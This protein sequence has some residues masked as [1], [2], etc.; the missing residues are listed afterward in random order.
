MVTKQNLSALFDLSGKTAMVTGSSRGIGL[1]A[2][3]ALAEAGADTILADLASLDDATKRIQSLGKRALP[4]KVD[5]SSQESI[6][7][8]VAEGVHQFGKVDIIV[9]A[10]GTNLR[11]PAT[12][13]NE[14]EWGIVVNVNLRGTFFCCQEAGKQMIAQQTGGKIINIASLLS[15]F[16]VPIPGIVPYAC[17]KGGVGGLTRSLAMEWAKYKINVNAIGP[18]YVSTD[19]TRSIHDDPARSAMI[20]SRIPLG[21]WSVPEDLK[22]A[23]VFLASHASDYMTGQIMFVDGGWTTT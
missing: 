20:E 17:S 6:R 11:K 5:V 21:R 22:G 19:L 12:D 10:A 16:G 1:A 4:V 14:E 7:K 13:W 15:A 18:G 2:A 23:F 9:N 3:T 8:A